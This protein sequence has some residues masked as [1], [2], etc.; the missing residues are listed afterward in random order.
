VVPR[1]VGVILAGGAGIRAGLGV[2]KQFA[3]LAGRPVL[4]HSVATF[5]GHPDVDAVVVVLPA[6]LLDAGREIAERHAVDA[7][8]AG[9]ATRADSARCGLSAAA[10]VGADAVLIHDAA[11]PLVASSTIT[12]CIAVLADAE[13]VAVTVPESDTVVAVDG[14]TVVEQLERERLHRCQTP[15]GFRLETI[16]Q[17]HQRAASDAAFEPTDDAGVV[18]RYLPDVVVRVVPGT[19]E[20][21]KVTHATDLAVAEALVGRVSPD[22]ADARSGTPRH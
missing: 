8:V 22:A 5:A 17:A 21:I 9:G 10:D 7:V 4:E 2:P 12:A 15:Q 19:P 6:D 16:L 1:I 13:A 11:R 18:L 20:N 3:P 14:G